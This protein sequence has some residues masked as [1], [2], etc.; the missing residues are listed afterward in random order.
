VTAEQTYTPAN[1]SR[2][3]VLAMVDMM[4]LRKNSMTKIIET[5]WGVTKSGRE[6]SPWQRARAEYRELTGE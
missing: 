6:D 3:Q 4:K 2:E 5:L 1:L